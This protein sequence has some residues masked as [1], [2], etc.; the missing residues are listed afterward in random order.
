MFLPQVDSRRT[1]LRIGRVLCSSQ[2]T[3]LAHFVCRAHNVH[4]LD[5]N[6]SSPCCKTPNLLTT[7]RCT[8]L[9]RSPVGTIKVTYG[10][11][12]P[13]GQDVLSRT[14]KQTVLSH[15]I[16]RRCNPQAKSWCPESQNF[17]Y[18]PFGQAD[19]ARV[20]LDL[21]LPPLKIRQ[22]LGRLPW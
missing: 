14:R 2:V 16:L 17:S 4:L 6:D 12:L 20:C 5:I 11:C 21:Q 13:V 15:T 1:R 7:R 18:L 9:A 19:W 22:R 3:P 10:R 8:L